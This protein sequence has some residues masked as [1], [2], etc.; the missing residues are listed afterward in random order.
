MPREA[1]QRDP[2]D[3]LARACRPAKA[4]FGDF[5]PLQMA[6]ASQ[7]DLAKT[8]AEFEQCRFDALICGDGSARAFRSGS[9]CGATE[10]VGPV[11]KATRLHLAEF[12]ILSQPFP[13]RQQNARQERL[14]FFVSPP[15]ETDQRAVGD[16]KPLA[17]CLW[18]ILDDLRS[19]CGN[20]I[21]RPLGQRPG[22]VFTGGDQ[23][24]QGRPARSRNMIPRHP[25][26]RI[27]ARNPVS[28]S[29]CLRHSPVNDG[30]PGR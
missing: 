5:Q 20:E 19:A 16:G 12:I 25:C 13:C 28:Q 4:L 15:G 10:D 27:M 17:L 21:H 9:V 23:F 8:G 24:P 18:D 6:A 26:A 1:L 30:R 7:S 22:A 14:S 3:D 11:A 2:Q 29:H